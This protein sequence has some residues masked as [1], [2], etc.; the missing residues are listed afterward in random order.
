MLCAVNNITGGFFPDFYHIYAVNQL[1]FLVKHLNNAAIA[2]RAPSPPLFEKEWN[3]SLRALIPNGPH[4]LWIHWPRFMARFS[5]YDYP[6][7][8]I[9]LSSRRLLSQFQN[10]HSLIS[11]GPSMG[12]METQRVTSGILN[13]HGIRSFA[14]C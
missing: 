2:F 12:S 8:R 3:I 4:P 11:I 14:I 1:C 7:Q 9:R 10:T 6:V 13:S 5:A